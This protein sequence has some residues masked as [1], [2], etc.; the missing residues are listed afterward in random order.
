MLPASATTS[1][2]GGDIDGQAVGD[3]LGYNV[4]LS[5]DGS[6]VAVGAP[7]VDG[8]ESKAG[9]VRV[10]DWVGGS[11]SQVGADI[12]GEAAGDQSGYW[13]S[14]SSDGS[15]VAIGAP[16]NDGNGSGAGHVRVYDLVDGSW[17]QVG[18]DIDGEAAGD[19]SGRAVSLSSDGSRLAIGASGSDGNGSDAGHVRV[20]DLVDGSWSQ[21]G[22]DIDGEAAGD[23]SGVSVS[24]SSDGSRVAIGAPQNDGNGSGAGHVRVYDLVGGSWSQVGADIDGEAAGDEFGYRVA[25]SA[26]ASSL[27]VGAPLNDGNGTDAG[28]VRV[29]DLV[30]GSWSQVGADIDGEAAG[31]F[32]GSAVALSSGGSRVVIGAHLNDGS[33]VNTGHVRVYDLVD[34]SWSQ[35]GADIDGEASDAEVDQ[36]GH[37][38]AISGVG[39]RIAI[40]ALGNDG[41]AADAGHTRVF[42]LAS[43]P[44]TTT[45]TTAPPTTTTAPPTTTTVPPPPPVTTTTVPPTT[46]TTTTVP[47]TTTTT[48]TTVPPTTTTTT[49]V[50]VAPPSTSVP[51]VH[52]FVDVPVDGWRGEA[53]S[54]MQASGVTRGC[55]A[56]EF[57]PDAQM[58]R[59]QQ[60]TFLYRYA[61][62]PAPGSS[63]P[64]TDVSGGRYYSDAVS[65]AWNAG[66]T[67]GVS[68]TSFG[69]GLAVTRGQAVTFLWRQA[70]SPPPVGR[71][72]FTD[73]AG[74]R[75]YS[76][77]VIWAFEQGVTTGMSPVMFGPDF[78]VTRVQFAAFLSRY[79][80]LGWN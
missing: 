37:S 14:L 26:D 39:D 27:A 21:V 2:V 34:G 50:V 46:T 53:V 48:T 78:P 73:V 6:R 13:V 74:G 61:G 20:Y 54:W 57:C 9:Y 25:L 67:T 22:A 7:Q 17:S 1:Q 44:P 68:S 64:F 79:D 41:A 19:L 18:G 8:T 51:F 76:D 31:D 30:D 71:N 43:T 59:E 11:W 24:L 75:Y 28:H 5:N 62:S 42:E 32:S 69:T 4:S 60:L 52:S 23:V 47:P 35:V 45:T 56:S 36:S 58:T 15:R 63:H 12:N 38:V 77:A 3:W 33:G 10:Y 16:Q 40:G 80:K 29:Y 65:W 55:S 72:P 66:V 49:T 70:G